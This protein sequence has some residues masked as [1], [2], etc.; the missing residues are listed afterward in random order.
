MDTHSNIKA[1]KAATIKRRIYPPHLYMRFS[2]GQVGHLL[3]KSRGI[4]TVL[5][6][7]SPGNFPKGPAGKNSGVENTNSR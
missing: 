7:S 6:I 1:D 5:Q 2:N 3:R 4:L